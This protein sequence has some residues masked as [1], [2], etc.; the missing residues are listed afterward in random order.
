MQPYTASV[1]PAPRR[2]L[3]PPPAAA[4]ERCLGGHV[5]GNVGHMSYE[6]TTHGVAIPG[7]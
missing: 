3:P 7:D 5:R 1:S 6:R 4:A 2:G